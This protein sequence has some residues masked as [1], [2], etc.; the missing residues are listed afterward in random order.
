MGIVRIIEAQV[1]ALHLNHTHDHVERHKKKKK[2]LATPSWSNH[3]Q[4]RGYQN[5]ETFY[6]TISRERFCGRLE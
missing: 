3:E 5:L 6:L 1:M 2:K 4:F